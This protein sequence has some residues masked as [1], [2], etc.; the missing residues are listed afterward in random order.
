MMETIIIGC[1]HAGYSLKQEILPVLNSLNLQ[2]EDMGCYNQDSVDY[3]IYAQKVIQ[4]LQARPGSRGILICGTGLGMSIMANRCPGI[5]AAL[6]YNIYA[7]MMSR[8]HNDSNV[9]VLGGR[10][11]GSGLAREIIRV[12]L[13]TPF[14]GGRHQERLDLIE[15]LGCKFSCPEPGTDT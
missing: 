5:R 1:D 2:V 12:W 15:R 10:V 3:P 4:S 13:A 14:E 7:A 6:C 8:Q 9:L 11:T